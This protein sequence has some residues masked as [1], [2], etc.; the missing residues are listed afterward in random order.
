MGVYGALFFSL[1]DSRKAELHTKKKKKKPP[2]YDRH[3]HK[4]TN[5]EKGE[6]EKREKIKI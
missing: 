4:Q 2:S 1:Y 5:F 3:T 6:M